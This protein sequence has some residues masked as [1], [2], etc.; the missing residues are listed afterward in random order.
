MQDDTYISNDQIDVNTIHAV[1]L[2][3]GFTVASVILDASDATGIIVNTRLVMTRKD[4]A[5]W[6][7]SL[8]Q[9][10]ALE[11]MGW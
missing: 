7:D 11:S 8:S 6:R 9:V 3:N 5:E 4:I 10:D 1:L 2:R